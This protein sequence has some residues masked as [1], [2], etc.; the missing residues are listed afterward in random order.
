MK[1]AD[2]EEQK[3]KKDIVKTLRVKNALDILKAQYESGF[4][5]KEL[6]KERLEKLDNINS[7]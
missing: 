1:F 2:Y 5:S 6:Y 3:I 7:Q 4:I